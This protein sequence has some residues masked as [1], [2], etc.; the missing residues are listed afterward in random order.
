MFGHGQFG[1][2][3]FGGDIVSAAATV[4]GVGAGLNTCTGTGTLTGTGKSAGALL[5]QARAAATLTGTAPMSGAGVVQTTWSVVLA[6]LGVLGGRAICRAKGTGIRRAT[7]RLGGSGQGRSYP[8]GLI[9]IGKSHGGGPPI[10]GKVKIA[11]NG[12]G[13]ADRFKSRSIGA[14]GLFIRGTCRS[15]GAGTLAGAGVMNVSALSLATGRGFLVASYAL[16]L[17]SA[18]GVSGFTGLLTGTGAAGGSGQGEAL[19]SVVLGS[20][21]GGGGGAGARRRAAIW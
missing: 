20:A 4:A 8:Q 5:S 1:E 15:M 2:V 16:G 11:A 3:P 10:K 6:G 13:R 19:A 9:G 12:Y 18:M 21:S 17:C 14:P 7:G